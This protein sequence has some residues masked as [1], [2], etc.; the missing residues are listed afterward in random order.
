MA[1]EVCLNPLPPAAPHCFPGGVGLACGG[2]GRYFSARYRL[3]GRATSCLPIRDKRFEP[4][5]QSSSA[6]GSQA[7]PA[8]SR[9]TSVSTRSPARNARPAHPALRDRRTSDTTPHSGD[10]GPMRMRRPRRPR[11]PPRPPRRHVPWCRGPKRNHH[12]S[13]CRRR[14]LPLLLPTR[15][16]GPRS[17][18]RPPCLEIPRSQIHH[19]AR[20]PVRRPPGRSLVSCS[21]HSSGE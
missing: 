15:S 2:G 7:A 4:A 19:G 10:A 11:A 6:P 17:S 8:S 1:T 13:R 16:A 14:R 21:P 9:C 3:H 5:S 12:A 18:R 20:T